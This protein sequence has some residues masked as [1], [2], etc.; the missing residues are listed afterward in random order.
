MS[1]LNAKIKELALL[2]AKLDVAEKILQSVKFDVNA[3]QN[4]YDKLE[5]EVRAAALEYH[6]ITG[7]IK[8]H[9]AITI[10]QHTKYEFN[11]DAA[12]EIAQNRSGA[13]LRIKKEF[14]A[15]AVSAV[16]SWYGNDSKRLFEVDPVAMKNLFK[17]KP[18]VYRPATIEQ[19]EYITALQ[20]KLGEYILFDTE[21]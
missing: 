7:D 10:R 2:R 12:F 15:E 18:D 16:L 3:I 13:G 1:S 20:A 19:V 21:E 9:P 14:V 4:D 11:Y 5:N 17:E 8:P 6:S